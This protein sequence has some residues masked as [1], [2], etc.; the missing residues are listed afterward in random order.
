MPDSPRYPG[1]HK[2]IINVKKR[3]LS[4][5]KKVNSINFSIKK[6]ASKET[7]FINNHFSKTISKSYTIR[8]GF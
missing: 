6:Y 8:K 1:N 2:L 3:H 5:L 7:V 4:S